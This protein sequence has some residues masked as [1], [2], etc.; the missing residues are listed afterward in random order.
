MTITDQIRTFLK[1]L[2]EGTPFGYGAIGLR[3]DQ[4]SAAAKALERMVASG[5]VKRLSKGLFCHGPR[6]SASNT[7]LQII[8]SLCH[9]NGIRVAYVTGDRLL[10]RLGLVAHEDHY[11]WE[12]AQH[13]RRG[14]FR[15]AHLE[16]MAV[17]S[18]IP[19]FEADIPVLELL[20]ALRGFNRWAESQPKQGIQ[21][22]AAICSGLTDQQRIKLVQTAVYYPAGTC[23][24]LGA[25]ISLWGWEM[26]LS[27]LR[28]RI[29]PTSRYRCVAAAS[30]LP[31]GAAWGLNV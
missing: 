7:D 1:T 15:K 8:D 10:A 20:D 6:D 11:P 25:L 23:A 29:N 30:A 17:A 27:P 28:W 9:K 24:L 16:I 19:V 22:L 26:D 12:I 31:T 5:Q 21:N 3:P 2:P 13:K 18:A 4:G 14:T